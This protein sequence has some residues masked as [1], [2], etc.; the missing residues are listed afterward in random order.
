MRL[1][2]R[3]TEAARRSGVV[4]AEQAFDVAYAAKQAGELDAAGL[5]AALENMRAARDLYLVI[6]RSLKAGV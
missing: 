2:E 1:T 6:L 3:M 5:E 4:A